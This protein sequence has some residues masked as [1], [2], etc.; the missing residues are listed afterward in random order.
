MAKRVFPDATFILFDAFQEAEFLYKDYQY[1]INVL[2]DVDNKVV[3]FYKNVNMPGG[4]SY[5]KEIGHP[6]SAQIFPE[7]SAEERLTKRLETIVKENNFPLPDFIKIDV[8]GA[9]KDIILGGLEIIKN[10]KHMVI[11]MQHKE[12]NQGAPNVDETLPYIESLGF[13]CTNH[14]LVDNGSDAD[15]T[16]SKIN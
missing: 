16:F 11:E 13:K 2:S 10:A 14:R 7:S 8:Q 15:Y 1:S 6:Q 4:N 5:Y 3:K 9:E 12:Y